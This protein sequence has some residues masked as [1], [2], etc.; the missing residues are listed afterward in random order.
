M[1]DALA[2]GRVQPGDLQRLKREGRRIVMVTAYDVVSGTVAR[3]AGVDVALVGDSA[4]NVVLGHESTRDISLDELITLA[5]AVRRGID[6][7]PGGVAPML[8]GDL[9]YGSYESSDDMAI[10]AARRFVADA[11]CDAVKLEG[12]GPMVARARAI[13]GAGIAVIGH[14]GLLPQ[15][16]E[17]GESPRVQG[18]TVAG[19]LEIVRDALALEGAGCCAL[20]LEAV[21][22]PVAALLTPRVRIPVIGIGAGSAVDGQVLVLHDLLGLHDGHQP[23]FAK[24]YAEL[25]Q[26]MTSGVRAY[27]D[28]VRSGAYPTDEHAY[29]MD[30]SERAALAEALNLEEGRG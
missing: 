27:A 1:S 6:R 11:G 3:A 24:R 8:A 10:A 12:G 4:A 15:H 2:T 28:E 20:V 17:V 29:A 9:T 14:L 25:L 22:A 30:E 13:V 23:R 5:G 21:P 19:A 18:R 7:T 26:A 16:V